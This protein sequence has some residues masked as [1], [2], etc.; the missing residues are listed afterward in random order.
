MPGTDS[1]PTS[2]FDKATI[3]QSGFLH[4]FQTAEV[5][6]IRFHI[7]KS[8]NGAQYSVATFTRRGRRNEETVSARSLTVIAGWGH[9]ALATSH[10]DS[11]GPHT[12]RSS[13]YPPFSNEWN[14]LLDDYLNTLGPNLALI[15]DGRTLPAPESGP[16]TLRDSSRS[17][18]PG[19]PKADPP[20]VDPEELQDALFLEGNV[21]SV[22]NDQY[23]RNA[24]ARRACIDH[25]GWTC[26]V[27]STNLSEVYGYHGAEFIHV[28]HRVPL[29][30]IGLTYQVDPIRDLVPVC[31]NCHAILHR[32][33]PP[34]T[35]EALAEMVRQQ[36]I[37]K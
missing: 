14:V 3:F 18:T 4:G 12:V 27:C 35:V 2:L 10:V 8:V 22:L 25:Y 1:L 23:E 32:S 30:E 7:S 15:F 31:P 34:L 16:Q 19:S 29:S 11:S 24:G 9:P 36:R 37:G 26:C 5:Q 28:H 21:Q 33:T 17:G 6:K 20:S 13:K